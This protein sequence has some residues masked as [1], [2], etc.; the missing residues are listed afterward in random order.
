MKVTWKTEDVG[1][2]RR[3]RGYVEVDGANKG[4]S[5]SDHANEPVAA[6]AGDMMNTL[7]TAEADGACAGMDTIEVHTED[8]I[9]SLGRTYGDGNILDMLAGVSYLVASASKTSHA[10]SEVLAWASGHMA[11]CPMDGG[12]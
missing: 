4:E 12:S 11:A 3:L 1:V 5:S 6:D 2:E 9:E 10:A 7:E 8:H